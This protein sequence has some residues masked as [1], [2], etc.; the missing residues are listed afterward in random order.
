LEVTTYPAR[1][2]VVRRQWRLF[3]EDAQD[4]GQFVDLVVVREC[5][6]QR[7]DHVVS[8]DGSLD[9]RVGSRSED[10]HDTLQNRELDRGIVVRS[11]PS[12]VPIS[13]ILTIFV[14]QDLFFG[15]DIAERADF[16]QDLG[17]EAAEIGE[18]ADIVRR[19][20]KVSLDQAIE[21]LCNGW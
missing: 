20:V 9:R 5:H 13:Q 2:H 15:E 17:F 4:G 10:I 21:T 3:V 14:L 7:P 12:A 6:S 8:A 18:V 19:E 1:I 16:S 11:D